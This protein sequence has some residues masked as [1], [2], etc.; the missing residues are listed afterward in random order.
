MD[1]DSVQTKIWSRCFLLTV[2]LKRTKRAEVA[3]VQKNLS[4]SN[5]GN[6]RL[7]GIR[8][9][10]RFRAPKAVDGPSALNPGTTVSLNAIDKGHNQSLT[11]LHLESGWQVSHR[12]DDLPNAQTKNTK[13]KG[14]TPNP[15]SLLLFRTILRNSI[16]SQMRHTY[17]TYKEVRKTLEKAAVRLDVT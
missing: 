16:E 3:S 13:Y 2:L 9:L 14:Y 8:A 15:S 6:G 10:P 5:Q 1:V 12:N 11:S 4:W 7:P 17:I